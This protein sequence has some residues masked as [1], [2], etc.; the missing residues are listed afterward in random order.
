[1]SDPNHP[2]T[3]APSS[4]SVQRPAL[5]ASDAEREQVAEILR[6][7]AGDGRIDVAELDERLQVAYSTRTKAELEALTADVVAGPAVPASPP[8][9]LSVRAGAGGTR[10]VVSIMG[11][12]DRSGR[13][14]IA[15]RCLVLNIMGGS[16]LDL[17]HAE[18][19]DRDTTIT[20]VSIMGGGEIRVPEGVEV[21]V[22]KV[23]IMG[24]NDAQLSDRT[25][26][27]GAPVIHIRLVSIMGGFS[28][29]QG[30]RRSRREQRAE[31]R[32]Q[33]ELHP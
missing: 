17:T 2:A 13:W 10:F 27:P 16:E 3:P 30:P 15:P 26:P 1:M 20:V 19:A 5:R 31:R 7:A 33:R 25:P 29:E 32:R 11:G 24:G 4:D 21:H 28:V 8:A 23:A 6:H 22:S 18:L 9:G 14:R 12:H